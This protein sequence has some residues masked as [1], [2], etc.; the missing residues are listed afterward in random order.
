MRPLDRRRALAYGG[1]MSLR[2]HYDRHVLP[3]LID[4][5]MRA[6]MASRERQQLIPQAS[7]AVLEIGVGSG[8][9]MPFYSRAVTKLFALEPNAKLR[10][11][12]HPKAAKTGFAVEFLGL[13]GEDIPLD[14]QSI[15]TVVTTWTL[16]TIPDPAKA[17]QG[18]FRVLK[19]GGRLLFVEHG[20]APHDRLARWQDRLSPAWSCCAGGCQ[21]NRRPD[22]L[23]QQAGFVLDEFE[24]GYLDGPKLLTYHY[25]GLARRA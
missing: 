18:M 21:L 6:P 12:A 14:D 9:N 25:K 2:E 20:R 11:K 7:G 8:L 17:L 22:L 3:H 10:E 16:C 23:I 1:R 19:P 13:K 5:T 24:Q 15:D 4:I